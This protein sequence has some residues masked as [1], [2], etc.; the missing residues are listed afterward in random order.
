MVGKVVW[1]DSQAE[2]SFTGAEGGLVAKGGGAPTFEMAGADGIYRPATVTISAEKV[3]LRS[4]KVKDPVAVRYAWLNNP[5]PLLSNADGLA[6]GPFRLEKEIVAGASSRGFRR[7]HNHRTGGPLK[8]ACNNGAAKQVIKGS[9][10]VRAKENVIRFVFTGLFEDVV[11]READEGNSFHFQTGGLQGLGERGEALFVDLDV[12]VDVR[13]DRGAVRDH[14][15]GGSDGHIRR[16]R[17]R[18]N[19]KQNDFG[20]KLSGESRPALATTSCDVSR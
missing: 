12:F 15:Y 13:G 17:V 9:V 4:E 14:I 3:E 1:G 11:H 20:G 10:A 8:D 16:P 2:L 18:H 19:A 5:I 7:N 6:V